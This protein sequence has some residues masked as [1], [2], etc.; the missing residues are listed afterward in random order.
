MGLFFVFVFSQGDSSK[1]FSIGS[2][3]YKT[4]DGLI[5]QWGHINELEQLEG[6]S[7]TPI[8]FAV[9]FPN[10]C[11]NVQVSPKSIDKVYHN[12]N[13]WVGVVS[14]TNDNFIIYSDFAAGV[15]GPIG[16][17]WMAIGY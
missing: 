3:Y 1:S 4:S 2:G 7:P 5:I 15:Q 10:A 6:F 9:S 12:A 14:W 11:L 8:K 13:G 17:F 16:A